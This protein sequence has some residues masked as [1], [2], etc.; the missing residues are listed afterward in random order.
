MTRRLSLRVLLFAFLATT[1]IA[2]FAQAPTVIT[3]AATAITANGARLN[4]TINSNEDP[5]PI[6]TSVYFQYG[7]TT[8]YGT[9]VQGTPIAVYYSSP[10]P[11]YVDI[12]GLQAATTYH[13]R[14]VGEKNGRTFYGNDRTFTTVTGPP[15]VTTGAATGLTLTQATLNGTVNA[16][17]EST[18]VTFEYGI[19]DSYGTTVTA[20]QSPVTGGSNTA[21]SRA[22]TGLSQGTT[23]HYRAVGANANGTTYGA[24]MTFTTP[25]I[26][27]SINNVSVNEPGG[28]A[29]FT[30]SLSFASTDVVTV[31]YA[32]ADNT[33]QAGSDYTSASNTLIFLP[34]EQTKT[35]DIPILNNG[36]YEGNESFYVNLSNNVNAR[37]ADG[38]GV[39]TIYDN[40][41]RP[42]I[43][44]SDLVVT[45]I[46]GTAV[47]TV[48]LSNSSMLETRVD[49]ATA[50]LTAT[51]GLDYTA[52]TGTL[53]VPA[54]NLV[55]T[56]SVPIL[57]NSIYE[58]D[59]TFTLSLTNPVNAT[60]LDN[61][62]TATIYDDDPPPQLNISD[63][64]AV[65]E[66]DSGTVI[67]SFTVTLS[68][69]SDFTA[70]VSYSTSNG[71][72]TGGS[73]FLS[74]SGMLVFNPGELTK[75][76]DVT[77]L[78][79]LL[80]EFDETFTVTL[81]SPTDATIGDGTGVGTITDNDPVPT[82]SIDDVSVTEGDAGTTNAT[83]IATLSAAS[84]KTI[85]VDYDTTGGTASS[86]DDYT[87]TSNTL[88]IAPG[89]TT[90][91]INV[92]ILGDTMYEP[93]ETITVT[94][95][96]PTNVTML[97]DSALCSI[98]ND[99][100]EPTVSINDV[101]VDEGN[102]GTT[103]MLF[104][105]SLS[106]PSYLT[107]TVALATSDG[108]AIA[109]DD[110]G[111]D[112]RQVTFL[113]GTDTATV[114]IDAYGDRDI[115]TDETFT[116][117]LSTPVNCTINDGTGQGTI[118][119]DDW[120]VTVSGTI[121]VDANP[122]QGVNVT[123]SHDGHTEVTASDGSYSYTF[124]NGPTTT[125]TPA[126]P[127]FVFTPASV[128]LTDIQTDQTAD[129][130]ANYLP[131][132]IVASASSHGTIN[133]AG[134][135]SVEHGTHQVF[136]FVPDPG[137]R[138]ADVQ[139]DGTSVKIRDHYTFT[140]VTDDH[141]IHVVFDVDEQPVID[142]LTASQIAGNAVLDVTFNAEA[143][144]P[145]G[146]PIIRYLWDISG[147]RA[148]RTMTRNGVLDYR[149]VVPGDYTLTLTVMDDERTLSEPASVEIHVGESTPIALPIPSMFDFAPLKEK[150]ELDV[151]VHMINVFDETAEVELQALD[152]GGHVVETTLRWIPPFGSV[153]LETDWVT[154]DN[155]CSL[156]AVADRYVIVYADS[157]GYRVN[158]KN[159]LNTDLQSH[160][161]VPHIA[162]DMD[163]WDTMT[164][165]SNANPQLLSFDLAGTTTSLCT[166]FSHVYDLEAF[167]GGEPD[168]ASSWG[169]FAADARDPFTDTRTMTGFELFV[170]E[171]GDGAAVR[172]SERGAS[173]LFIPHIANNTAL[174]WT[175][176]AFVNTG[177]EP[178]L[179]TFTWL[180]D[181]GSFVGTSE[182]EVL[183]DHKVKGL[184]GDLF[185]ESESASWG[186]VTVAGELTGVQLFGTLN[187]GICGIALPHMAHAN[188]V[189]PAIEYENYYWTGIT[190]T[191]VMD[192]AI[193]VTLQLV[194][195]DGM[196]KATEIE[197]ID[198]LS[199]FKAVV[200]DYFPDA[201][202]RD[203]DYVRFNANG[204]VV[205][206]QISGRDDN[207]MMSALAGVR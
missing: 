88:T 61:S 29:T 109:G 72:A 90:G 40:E 135:I 45:E 205:A 37:I 156:R 20:D 187:T 99:D 52:T 58:A 55:G 164:F 127:E 146:G 7:T 144:D 78:G 53:A 5:G 77:V 165:L 85:T 24:D 92:P 60:I 68:S 137:Y 2:A 89:T 3:N 206:I 38:Q 201:T 95:S 108:T 181:D 81:V 148:D 94:L 15:I 173:T 111:A 190:I 105:V 124:L 106:N 49:Y 98:F 193:T 204:P 64:P 121:T 196:V 62:A 160:L 186:V 69:T 17:G 130:T 43:S 14:V 178:A 110:Y 122:V 1:T 54:G 96:N 34:G 132:D 155:A 25:D 112:T 75:T 19:T 177:D 76:I 27:L 70:T 113:S 197:T 125:V 145:D 33:A 138:I 13:F 184:Q 183:P 35:I 139:V 141:T 11:V 93:D 107:V 195:K 202:L 10:E 50:D 74:K 83:F 116:C 30:V 176:Y 157:T 175:G 18:T 51:A 22:I 142:S 159:T 114:Q 84:E 168:S 150:V 133:P 16:N 151:A 143:H 47:F 126:H 185:P 118:L 149:F 170:K 87:A 172:L 162:E 191:N 97:D 21:V 66:P 179:A 131:H 82:L 166:C 80:D 163:F 167:M 140:N 56:I 67:S 200:E 117:T 23:Y 120:N 199:R 104:T 26:N 73:D 44:I 123:F 36:I 28:T 12:S 158:T 188:G 59:E 171:S 101:Q 134:T 189:L 91:T 39:C 42:A 180:A 65:M 79:D 169:T 136:L 102:S 4:G 71:T 9:T 31:N 100:P 182:L 129:F 207:R 8:S 128:L 41:D 119:N 63:A 194:G 203:G 161:V 152:S 48:A 6:G 198:A 86:G 46:G 115:E 174:F 32:T 153:Y 57:D 192:E 154:V 103:P 147:R